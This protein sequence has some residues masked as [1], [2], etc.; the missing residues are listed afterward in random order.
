MSQAALAQAMEKRGIAGIYPQTILKVEK[1]VRSL[2]FTEGLALAKILGVEPEDLMGSEVDPRV[3]REN[4]EMQGALRQVEG[5][6]ND[7]EALLAYW[8]SRVSH[9]QHPEAP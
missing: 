6:M 3:L 9:G 8:R 5:L 7:M 1:G 4:L 2:R